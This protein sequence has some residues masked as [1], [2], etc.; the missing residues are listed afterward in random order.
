MGLTKRLVISMAAGL[1]LAA[2]AQG[3]SSPEVLDAAR[4]I[5]YGFYN[6]DARAIEAAVAVLDRLGDAPDALYYRD[7][8]GLRLAQLDVVGRRS[9]DLLAAC[10]ERA[11]PNDAKGVVAAE[12]WVLVAACAVE[13]GATRRMEVA[14]AKARALDDDNPRIALVAAWAADHARATALDAEPRAK[15][16]QGIVAGFDDWNAP[17]DAPAWG[18]AEA[19]AELG[20]IELA[21]GDARAARDLIERSLLEAPDYARAVEL[22]S[23]LLGGASRPR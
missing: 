11:V 7:L 8:A 9:A 22:R 15:A 20:A 13:A 3:A 19:L 18:K 5:E 23:R 12:A 1:A 17:A 2:A 6:R 14:L 10:V 4:R 21:R 16:W